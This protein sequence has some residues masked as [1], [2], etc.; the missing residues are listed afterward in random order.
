MRKKI[1]NKLFYFFTIL[2]YLLLLNLATPNGLQAQ[3]NPQVTI[4]YGQGCPHCAAVEK[5]INDNQLDQTFSITYKEV[6]YNRDNAKEL[7]NLFT[8]ANIPVSQQGVPL[9]IINNQ[10]YT[11]DAPIIS[12]LKKLIPSPDKQATVEPTINQPDNNLQPDQKILS[13][14]T[15]KILNFWTVTSAALIDAINPC[16]FAVLIILM[17]TVLATK[18]HK[19]ALLSGIIFSLAI[20]LSYFAM[21]IGLY[22]AIATVGLTIWIQRIVGILAIIL[23][24]FNLKDVFWYGK[25][26]LMEVPLSWRPKMKQFIQSVT[27]P[28]LA[29]AVGIIVSL[30]LLPCTSGPY[31]V[32]LGMLGSSATLSLAIR[33]LLYYNLIF[34]LPMIIITLAIYF[35]LNPEKLEA[36][37]QR[38]LKTLH[39]IAGIILLILGIYILI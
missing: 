27:N 28:F 21:G 29:F 15:P 13:E 22:S 31:I 34:V 12:A 8:T 14:E 6:Y 36:I 33:W 1:L 9:A 38:R 10:Y 30:F 2:S 20:Y 24:L 25:G 37:R 18:D 32:I 26:F 17:A 3:S 16:A 7:A 5:Y 11:G 23:A 4:Y 35:G 19:K 39:A